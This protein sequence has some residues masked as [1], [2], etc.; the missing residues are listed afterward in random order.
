[1]RFRIERDRGEL[2]DARGLDQIQAR[3]LSQRY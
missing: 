2:K 3:F 1:L